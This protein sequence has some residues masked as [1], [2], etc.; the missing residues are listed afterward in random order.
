MPS[1]QFLVENAWFFL[2]LLIL[3]LLGIGIA[4]EMRR[5]LRAARKDSSSPGGRIRS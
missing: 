4:A 3:L 5:R 2:L 1:S